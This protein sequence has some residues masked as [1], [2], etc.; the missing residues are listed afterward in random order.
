MRTKLPVLQYG[1]TV[2]TS[3]GQTFTSVEQTRT[4]GRYAGL[5]VSGGR[6]DMRD[7]FGYTF[8]VADVRLILRD[9]KAIHVG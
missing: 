1:D 7:G 9:G 6:G 2:T 8:A 3:S 5:L 4:R